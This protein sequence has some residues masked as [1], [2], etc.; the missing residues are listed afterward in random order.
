MF[1]NCPRIQIKFKIKFMQ[2]L[3]IFF[4]IVT[5]DKIHL[6]NLHFEFKKPQKL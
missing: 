6:I 5:C 3:M 4:A 2:K 1:F